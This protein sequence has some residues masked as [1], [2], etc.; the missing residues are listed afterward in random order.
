MKN[1]QRKNLDISSPLSNNKPSKKLGRNCKEQLGGKEDNLRTQG[2]KIKQMKCFDFS[3]KIL[4][5]SR[6]NVSKLRSF[7]WN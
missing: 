4:S 3:Q 7:L 6:K 5:L 2:K 1:N